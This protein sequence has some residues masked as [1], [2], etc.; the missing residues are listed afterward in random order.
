MDETSAPD[1]THQNDPG[2]SADIEAAMN[3]LPEECRAVIILCLSHGMSH[4][5]VSN[6]TGLPLGTVKS[7]VARGKSKLRAF[8]FAYEISG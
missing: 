8:L 3:S 5:E 2:L 7:H 1:E 6:V 4:G